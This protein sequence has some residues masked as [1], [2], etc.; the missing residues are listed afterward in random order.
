MAEECPTEE[1]IEAAAAAAWERATRMQQEALQRYHSSSQ[2]DQPQAPPPAVGDP[3]QRSEI[4]V[5]A[6]HGEAPKKR[7]R[8]DID[9]S[10]P[11]ITLQFM[12][13][14][15]RVRK[16]VLIQL[17]YYEGLFAHRTFVPSAKTKLQYEFIDQ[18]AFGAYLVQRGLAVKTKLDFFDPN[19]YRSAPQ[20]MTHLEKLISLLNEYRLK[21]QTG[22]FTSMFKAMNV[23]E[24]VYMGAFSI[25]WHADSSYNISIHALNQNS[26]PFHIMMLP[27]SLKT[28]YLDANCP[29]V[30]WNAE[31]DSTTSVWII[32]SESECIVTL[33]PIIP[34]K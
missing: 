30:S 19:P 32:L 10:D 22:V 3:I 18:G 26:H 33:R 27:E 15:Y 29:L 34:N 28:Q 23:S 24:G 6:Q 4:D 8:V 25:L 9:E 7:T 20:D 2:E 11:V 31:M 16:S 21:P 12:D 14:T 1:I 17:P 5:I 13:Q